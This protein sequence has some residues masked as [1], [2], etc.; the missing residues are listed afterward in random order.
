MA[1]K[2]D[3]YAEERMLERY[4]QGLLTKEELDEFLELERHR[5]ELRER[6]LE[7]GRNPGRG[8]EERR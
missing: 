2:L 4:R 5:S 7:A 1:R 3:S 8:R 6:A